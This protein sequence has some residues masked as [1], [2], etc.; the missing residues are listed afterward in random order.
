MIKRDCK[1]RG[2]GKHSGD[3]RGE[4]SLLYV[5]NLLQTHQSASQCSL[6]GAIQ[7]FTCST[8]SVC[9]LCLHF[10]ALLSWFLHFEWPLFSLVNG[11]AVQKR[12]GRWEKPD[13]HSIQKR[14]CIQT[15]KVHST[16]WPSLP[17]GCSSA[18]LCWWHQ[19]VTTEIPY[20]AASF[21]SKFL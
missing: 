11:H 7:Q 14:K 13:R 18:V 12:Q 21:L 2:I 6:F 8:T 1:V 16:A 20:T 5:S 3:R 10:L 15:S 19:C 4:I 17:Q 9:P